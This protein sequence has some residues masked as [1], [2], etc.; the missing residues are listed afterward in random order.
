MNFG[1]D[2]LVILIRKNTMHRI[3]LMRQ[4]IALWRNVIMQPCWDGN[5]HSNQ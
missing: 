4:P 2:H 5:H 3:I 1:F